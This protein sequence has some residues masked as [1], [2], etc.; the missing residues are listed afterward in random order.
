MERSV[1]NADIEVACE[2]GKSEGKEHGDTWSGADMGICE[3]A[4]IAL[5]FKHGIQLDG[6]RMSQEGMDEQKKK[7]HNYMRCILVNIFMKKIMGMKC[8]DR[9]GGKF[10]FGLVGGEITDVEGKPFGN[11]ACEWHD[12]GKGGDGSG[13]GAKDRDL[14]EVMKRWNDRNQM[15][16][17]DGDWG[18]LG[19]AC[20]VEK[21]GRAEVTEQEAV[22]NKVHEEIKNVEDD[23]EQKVP[24]IIQAVKTCTERDKDCVKNLLKKKQQEEMKKGQ[25]PSSTA[26]PG[27]VHI[28]ARPPPPPP[29]RRPSTPRQ[30]PTGVGSQGD[31]TGKGRRPRPGT[32]PGKRPRPRPRPPPTDSAPSSPLPTPGDGKPPGSGGAEPAKPVAATLASPPSSGSGTTSTTTTSS[33]GGGGKAGYGAAEGG[34]KGKKAGTDDDCDWKSI[35]DE[36]RTQVYVLRNYDEQQLQN[37]KDV[38]QHFMDYMAKKDYIM[39]AM[40]ANCENSGWDDIDQTSTYYT[41]QTVADMIRCRLVSGALWFANG[42]SIAGKSRD[43]DETQ[44]RLRCELVN[45]F[46]YILHHKYCENKTPWKR[47]IKYAW[48]TVKAMAGE[49][50]IM[51]NAQGPVM[52]GDCTECGYKVTHGSVRAVDGDMVNLL[53]TEGRI[54]DKIGE[55]ERT[56]DCSVKW[57]EYKSRPGASDGKGRVDW[58]KIPEVKQEEKKIIQITK[59]AVEEVKNKIDEQLKTK[60]KE[61]KNTTYR[62]S[63]NTVHGNT[64]NMTSNNT[65]TTEAAPKTEG[66]GEDKT[67]DKGKATKPGGSQITKPSSTPSPSAPGELGRADTTGS[68][69]ATTVTPGQPQPPASPPA[70][71]AAG[72]QPDT[73]AATPKGPQEP[74]GEQKCKATLHNHQLTTGR[75]VIT[76]TCTP[77]EAL[78]G[79]NHVHDAS[80][81]GGSATE[82]TTSKDGHGSSAVV[83]AAPAAPE[84][85]PLTPVSTMGQDP[86]K[87]STPDVATTISSSTPGEPPTQ[88]DPVDAVPGSQAPVHSVD[89]STADPA[90]QGVAVGNDDPP[91]LNPPKPKPNPNPNQSGSSG[92]GGQGSEVSVP[93][94]N[95]ADP[96]TQQNAGSGQGDFTLEIALPTGGGDVGGSYGTGPTPGPKGN[97]P[98]NVQHD[99]PFFPDLTADILTAT[100]PVLFFLSAVTVAV[101]SYSRWKAS[102]LGTSSGN[103]TSQYGTVD[104]STVG[105]T[106]V[107]LSDATDVGK[108]GTRNFY[109]GRVMGS[110]AKNTVFHNMRRKLKTKVHVKN[111][112]PV[113]RKSQALIYLGVLFW[114]CYS[115]KGRNILR[116]AWTCETFPEKDKNL[117]VPGKQEVRREPEALAKQRAPEKLRVPGKQKTSGKL[118]VPWKIKLPR[119]A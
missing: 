7:I 96:N 115:K 39:D 37:M 8:L 11:V 50:G 54:M 70:P 66:S 15:N 36:K 60:A 51:A 21:R 12:A 85:Q 108:R 48:K 113:Q 16:I 57:T 24:E 77:D 32:A 94:N 38:L 10:A 27:E 47:G 117:E 98:H 59:E 58:K 3:L 65:T 107:S 22:K 49:G 119:K 101:V 81:N 19:K 105:T 82:H 35:E 17:G 45:A 106:T 4:Y 67:K 78:G 73:G 13:R 56:Q 84:S 42:D 92:G 95:Q 40:G 102:T 55:M 112:R 33:G 20:K 23:L 26:S 18:A 29:P 34:E 89:D 5:R 79:A 80:A 46:G 31:G 52:T 1:E 100:T 116:E 97:P 104:A 6:T 61:G 99:G 62:S 68:A 90:G 41:G 91:P 110:P 114:F 86:D 118:K 103:G 75:I 44:N 14:W 74:S 109:G 53:I 87:G 30:G 2:A 83:G 76:P 9:P 25:D 111:P 69:D 43:M 71:G 72:T 63:N 64:E 93:T 28:P 88:T